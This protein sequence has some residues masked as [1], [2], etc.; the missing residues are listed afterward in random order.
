MDPAYDRDHL[1]CVGKEGAGCF[2]F[3]WFLALWFV[4]CVS[5]YLFA[6]SLGLIIA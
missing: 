1:C 4:T 2:A 6:I 3:P 5:H